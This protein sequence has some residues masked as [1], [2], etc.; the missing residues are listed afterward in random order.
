LNESILMDT[1][2]LLRISIKPKSHG[3]IDKLINAPQ[4]TNRSKLVY[5]VRTRGLRKQG[6]DVIVLSLK[7][8]ITK[9]TKSAL[10][11]FRSC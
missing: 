4:Q 3:F 8:Q 6:D 7:I 5:L 11:L 1:G 2:Q 9:Q 10:Y